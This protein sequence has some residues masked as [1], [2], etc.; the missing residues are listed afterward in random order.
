MRLEFDLVYLDALR[1]ADVQHFAV[2]VHLALDPAANDA[3]NFFTFGIQQPER[4]DVRAAVLELLQVNHM[5]VEACDEVVVVGGHHAHLLRLL[6]HG[7][8]LFGG[9]VEHDVNLATFLN[10]FEKRP[11]NW[12][13]PQES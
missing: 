9:A 5:Q 11:V 8:Y 3:S 12:K 2:V 10:L 13:V 7:V 6:Q 4:R 1:G